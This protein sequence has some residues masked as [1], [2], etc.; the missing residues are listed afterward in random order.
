MLKLHHLRNFSAIGRTSSI[1]AA[2]KS[3]G[4][5]QP[6]LSKSLKEVED[7]LSV[8]LAER[9]S[10]GI[11][12]TPA[13]ARFLK[14]VNR[15]LADLDAAIDEARQSA[16]LDSGTL[17][18][19]LSPALQGAIPQA[20]LPL[21]QQQW[22]RVTVK[23]TE[24]YFQASER[25]L[26]DGDMDLYVGPLWGRTRPGLAG[27]AIGHLQRAAVAR[28]D[29]PLGSCRTLGKLS[30]ARWLGAGLYEG[31]TEELQQI[32][33]GRGLP[34]PDIAA[35]A[36]S[37]GAI[38]SI[39]LA[40]DLLAILPIAFHWPLNMTGLTALRVTPAIPPIPVFIVQRTSVPLT[41]AAQ[42]FAELVKMT[43]PAR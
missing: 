21:F 1:R 3:L 8:T 31:A 33:S 26:L 36:T 7:F 11:T 40:T 27:D 5:A 20:V 30:N 14:R 43:F 2:A 37:A 13:G 6:A 24:S 42:R 16:G 34:A 17:H 28:T 4:L 29:H 22:P 18:V 19:G 39:L 41:T 32:F 35:T 10:R 12:L 9:Q 25:L 38:T 15:L 23:F